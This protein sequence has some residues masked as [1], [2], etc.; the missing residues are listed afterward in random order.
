VTRRQPRGQL[1]SFDGC[2]STPFVIELG[3]LMSIHGQLFRGGFAAFV[4]TRPRKTAG[5]AETGKFVA[6]CEETRLTTADR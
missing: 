4:R 1:A 6:L 3:W 2:G 5:L